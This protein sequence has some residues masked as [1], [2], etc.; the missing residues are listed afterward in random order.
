MSSWADSSGYPF[1]GWARHMN[2]QLRMS[3]QYVRWAIGEPN[4]PGA[5]ETRHP[6]WGWH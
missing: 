5:A 4:G 2:R 1:V 6:G 3:L